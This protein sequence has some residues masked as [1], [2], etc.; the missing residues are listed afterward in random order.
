M[1]PN[2]KKI[3]TILVIVIVLVALGFGVYFGLKKSGFI[4]PDNNQGEFP[5]GGQGGDGGTGGG[6][7]GGDGTIEDDDLTQ[8]YQNQKER[9]FPLTLSPIV[10]FWISSATST[11]SA[12]SLLKSD[13]FY[14][15]AKGD[16]FKVKG[17]GESEPFTSSSFGAPLNI[18]QN[19]DGNRIVVK[20]SSKKFVIL[21][22]TKKVWQ[23]VGSDVSS[24]SFSPDGKSIA[25][26]KDGFGT[27]SLYV[28]DLSKTTRTA[29]LVSQLSAQDFNVDWIE[30]NKIL[31]VSKPSNGIIGE[32]WAVNLTSKT[33]S[34]FGKGKGYSSIFSTLHNFGLSFV[35]SL[36]SQ[37]EVDLIDKSGKKLADVSFSTLAD[38]CS[39]SLQQKVA[40]CSV[41]YAYNTSNPPTLPDDY[42]KKAVY[43]KDRIYS[44]NLDDSNID[45]ILDINNFIF[46]A[47]NLKEANNQLFFINRYEDKLYLYNLE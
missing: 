2:T 22:V 25:Y 4:T 38:K 31:L 6:G 18:T 10:D 12:S 23:D 3:L 45:V 16:V 42:L 21:D 30:S 44:I 13:V 19:K 15:D 34:S 9:L 11:A 32:V 20:F 14:I 29:T 26:L 8:Y 35:S 1:Q 28:V 46:D 33:I 36:K 37:M 43:F 41:P 5:D 17:P 40:Y 24:V 27:Q 39:F 47:V 7:T